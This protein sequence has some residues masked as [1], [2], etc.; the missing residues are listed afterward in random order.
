LDQADVTRIAMDEY[1]AMV[2]AIGNRAVNLS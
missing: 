1:G 2:P